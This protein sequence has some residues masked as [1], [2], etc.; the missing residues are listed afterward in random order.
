MINNVTSVEIKSPHDTLL[1][2]ILWIGVFI[3]SFAFTTVMLFYL[4]ISTFL[5]YLWVLVVTL[6]F[7]DT[8]W[9]LGNPAIF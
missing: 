5:H 6:D 7:V 4:G 8:I 1:Y 3:I 9:A 2:L